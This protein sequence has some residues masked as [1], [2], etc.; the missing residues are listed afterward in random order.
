METHKLQCLTWKK[1]AQYASHCHFCWFHFTF[2]INMWKFKCTCL[3]VQSLNARVHAHACAHTCNTSISVEWS[4]FQVSETNTVAVHPPVT[5]TMTT[6]FHGCLCTF[7]YSTKAE[8]AYTQKLFQVIL[9][10]WYKQHWNQNSSTAKYPRYSVDPICWQLKHCRH[11]CWLCPW[12][13]YNSC[14]SL[15]T[16]TVGVA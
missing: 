14:R 9:R 16:G 1:T 12:E 10:L 11:S 15:W 13:H 7:I 6:V 2:S 4:W 5:F 8:P 3:D